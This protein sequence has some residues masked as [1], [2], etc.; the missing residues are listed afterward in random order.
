MDPRD[1]EAVAEVADVLQIGARNMQNFDLLARGRPRR[2]AG[3]AQARPLGDD[4]GAAD[5]GRVHRSRRATTTVDPLRARHPHLRDRRRATRSTSAP[6]RSLKRETHLPVIV[7]PSPRRRAARPVL[8]L[9]RAAVAGGRR[10]HHRR[11]RTRA[12]EEAL[13]DGPQALHAD[14]FGAWFADVK[15][16]IDLMGKSSR[17]ALMAVAA[18]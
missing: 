2:Q 12:P 11:G 4:R 18:S 5:G 3:P 9:A 7:D 13:C 15:R 17:L 16:C 14:T 1:L 10:R 8:P 6:S